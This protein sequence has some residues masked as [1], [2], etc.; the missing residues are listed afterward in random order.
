MMG[1]SS[2]GLAYYLKIRPGKEKIVTGTPDKDLHDDDFF[3]VS[4]NYETA[5]VPGWFIS[6]DFGS[7][8][9]PLKLA[10]SAYLFIL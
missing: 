10:R 1:H 8:C 4:G 6:K 7:S 5:E 3:W 9:K 2:D